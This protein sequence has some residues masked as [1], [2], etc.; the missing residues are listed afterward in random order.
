M[1]SRRRATLN[2]YVRYVDADCVAIL[3]HTV[4]RP[5]GINSTDWVDYWTTG[6]EAVQWAVGVEC[7]EHYD[8]DTVTVCGSHIAR[9]Q[10][11]PSGQWFT[12][13]KA[14]QARSLRYRKLP[15]T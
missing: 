8:M 14:A 6:P 5:I 3:G 2:E 7:I 9:W 10:G 15:L 1:T 11:E 4:P 12:V 13:W